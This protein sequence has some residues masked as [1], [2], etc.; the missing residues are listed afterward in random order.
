[1][2]RL[3]DEEFRDLYFSRG[4][5]RTIKSRRMRLA[6]HEGKRPLGKPRRSWVD[7]IEIDLRETGMGVGMNWIGLAQVR[8][9]WRALVNTTMILLVP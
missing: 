3:Y 5:I 2:K 1:M 8:E 9:Q 4:I 7:N 6:G